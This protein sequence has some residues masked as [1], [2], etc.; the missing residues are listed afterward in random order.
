MF[1]PAFIDSLFFYCAIIG[2]GI[3]LLQLLLMFIGMDDGG[4]GEIGE[5][6]GIDVGDVDGATDSSGYWFYEIVSIRTL[7]A[8]AAFF[9]L[10]GKL[11]LS[12]NLAPGISLLL[13]L[14]AGYGAM[15][16]VYWIFKQIYRFETAGN[17]EIQNSVGLV[18][19]VYVPIEPGMTGKIHLKLQ[20]RTAEYA[21]VSESTERIITGAKVLVTE[22]VS[23]DTVKVEPT[24]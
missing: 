1:E 7:S 22:I 5:A 4:F 15:Y 10:V 24:A 17:Q 9:G 21:A 2:G 3:L 14:L 8:A 18:G 20:G 16:A 11:S 12:S 19:Q 13:G 6:G 23:S